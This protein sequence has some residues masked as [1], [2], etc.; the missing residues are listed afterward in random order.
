MT[1][2]T[3][4][5]IWFIVLGTLAVATLIFFA[6]ATSGFVNWN[7]SSWFNYWGKG[8]PVKTVKLENESKAMVL[9]S[10]D[11]DHEVK[12]DS[13]D[14]SITFAATAL[15]TPVL[16][17]NYDSDELE[18]VINS[19]ALGTVNVYGFPG[20]SSYRQ[21]VWFTFSEKDMTKLS[22]GYKKSIPLSEIRNKLTSFSSG[23]LVGTIPNVG[24]FGLFANHVNKD[25]YVNSG[26]STYLYVADT[27]EVTSEFTDTTYKVSCIESFYDNASY[28]LNV[29]PSNS[30]HQNATLSLKDSSCV[31]YEDGYLVVDLLSLSGELAKV[32]AL[33]AYYFIFSYNAY[34]KSASTGQSV[35]FP[36]FTRNPSKSNSFAVT[37]LAAPANLKYNA[38]TLTWDAVAGATE[39]ALFWTQHGAEKKAFVSTTSYTFDINALGEGEHTVRVRALGNLGQTAVAEGRI[40]SLT[41]YNAGS[42]VTQVVALTY[43]VDGD[44]VTKFVPYG[45]NVKDYLYDVEIKGREFGGWYYDSGFS[46]PVVSTDVIGGDTTIYARLSEKK[47]TEKQLSWW[48][49]NKWY[50]LIPVFI[51][52]GLA[53]VIAGVVTIRKKKAA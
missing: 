6:W 37:R 51:V 14:S 53:V 30:T 26:S 52:A 25:G 27:P 15:A 45:S 47:V 38:G 19:T 46:R 3:R 39:Y 7:A 9:T 31:S 10:A 32:P 43:N 44:V 2:I 42:V 17:F 36:Y 4:K 13:S 16:S 5:G 23:D 22:S 29:Y 28:S 18:V 12:T 20:I 41:A 11:V 49:Q 24:T 50:V 1:N 35:S 34:K 8:A 48:D 33:D 40:A 21:S